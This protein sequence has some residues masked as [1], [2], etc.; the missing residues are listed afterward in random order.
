MAC[1][2]PHL[3]FLFRR[4]SSGSDQTDRWGQGEIDALN[5]LIPNLAEPARIRGEWV[6]LATHRAQ[7]QAECIQDNRAWSIKPLIG[8]G[9]QDRHRAAG[10][11]R[12]E[13]PH[14][15][16]AICVCI[17]EVAEV[18][19]DSQ[20]V[21]GMTELDGEQ[22]SPLRYSNWAS[23]PLVATIWRGTDRT[24]GRSTAVTRKAGVRAASARL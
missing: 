12:I 18:A 16:A 5:S 24:A 22:G 21:A 4:W 19:H 1:V 10:T 2:S 7:H 14:E 20:V 9:I 8:H 6:D 13:E 11:K 15:Q 3:W 23:E 17:E